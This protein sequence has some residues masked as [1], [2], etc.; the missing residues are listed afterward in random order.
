METFPFFY[1]A[2]LICS[3]KSRIPLFVLQMQPKFTIH[4][5][6]MTCA[7]LPNFIIFVILILVG[8]IMEEKNGI[9]GFFSV[10]ATRY[11]QTPKKKE[12][13]TDTYVRFK[14]YT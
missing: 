14:I 10:L 3:E 1:F 7:H 5:H 12:K 4:I 13:W 6:V 11:C 8:R 9:V 2:L